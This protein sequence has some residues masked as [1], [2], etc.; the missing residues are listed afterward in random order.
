MDCTKI[1]GDNV[2]FNRRSL[3]TAQS[4]ECDM[5]GPL[6]LDLCRQERFIMNGVDFGLRL[7]QTKDSFRLMSD[8]GEC[9]VLITDAVLKVCKVDISPSVMATHNQIMKHTTTAKYPYERTEMKTFTIS[10][11]LLSF[12]VE[13]VF[14]GEVPNKVVMG[15]VST[16]SFF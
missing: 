7:W 4:I 13:D 8:I 14:Q 5:E 3:R 16:S 6:H 10:P 1:L 12:N 2:G 11:G 9:K 15:L